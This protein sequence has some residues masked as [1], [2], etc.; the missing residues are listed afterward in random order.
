ML[1]IHLTGHA[2]T[3]LCIN[4]MCSTHICVE[5]PGMPQPLVSAALISLIK[6][7]LNKGTLYHCFKGYVGFRVFLTEDFRKADTN[8]TKQ[9]PTGLF[10]SSLSLS[11]CG[12][13]SQHQPRSSD[14]SWHCQAFLTPGS[15]AFIMRGSWICS[16][17]LWG[18]IQ[19][20]PV[21]G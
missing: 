13:V 8:Q 19:P 7:S 14:R 9:T 15:R 11:V 21:S 16:S 2:V 6:D 12:R 3:A 10:S 20:F 4:S 5:I 1:E 17:L 18:S